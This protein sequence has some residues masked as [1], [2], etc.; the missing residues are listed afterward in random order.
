MKKKILLSSILTIALCLSLIAGSTFALFTSE[1]KVNIAVTSGKVEMLA[2]VSDLATWS[3]EDDKSLAGRMDGTF[4]QG[5]NVTFTDSVLSINKIIP[6]DKVSFLV[7]GTNNSNVTIMY[8]TVIKCLSGEVLMDGMKVTID[9]ETY[10]GLNSYITSWATLTE[11]SHMKELEVSVELPEEAGNIYQDLN[12]ELLVL[13]EAIQG[14]A[15]LTSNS[16]I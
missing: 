2:S 15:T 12:A 6:G 10:F 14:N 1:S 11:G 3:L 7:T 8:R 9:G 16:F 5:G 13:V 4:T